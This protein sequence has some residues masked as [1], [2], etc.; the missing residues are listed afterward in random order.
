MIMAT[1]TKCERIIGKGDSRNSSVNKDF[2]R[3]INFIHF[4]SLIEKFFNFCQ[5]IIDAFVSLLLITKNTKI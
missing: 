3:L 4:L 5:F 1:V 2:D